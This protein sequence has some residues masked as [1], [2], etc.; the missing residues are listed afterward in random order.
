M[1]ILHRIPTDKCAWPLL[2]GLAALLGLALFGPWRLLP[3][4]LVALMIFVGFFFRDPDRK[5]PADPRAFVSPADGVVTGVHLND[6]GEAGSVGGPW[7]SI[8]L[9]VWNVHVNRC[10][11]KESSKE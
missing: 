5:S 2:A 9:A 3:I 10:R 4:A 11:M 8:V 1:A 7:I 6:Q